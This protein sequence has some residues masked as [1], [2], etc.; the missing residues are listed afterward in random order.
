MPSRRVVHSA[1]S[2]HPAHSHRFI[3]GA[4]ALLLAIV[5]LGADW[6]LV[7]ASLRIKTQRLIAVVVPPKAGT[8]MLPVPFHKQEH[9]LSCEIASLRS[10]LLTLGLDVPEHMLLDAL[11]MDPT[12]KQWTSASAFTWGDP[13]EG[14]VGSIDGKMPNTGYGIHANGLAKIASLYAAAIPMRVNDATRLMNAIDAGHPVIAWSV[15][16]KTPRAYTWQT[17]AGKTIQGALYEHSVVVAG[18]TSNGSA[19]QKVYLIDPRTGPK[20]ESWEE[21]VWRTGFLN[22]QGLE[23]QQIRF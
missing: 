13:D 20:E 4:V 15:L 11:P 9:A 14:F 10:A 16:G 5:T 21:F 17:P 23:I 3:A 8:R 6:T 1:R 18:Y 2:P 19:I 22:Y 12:P 7:H